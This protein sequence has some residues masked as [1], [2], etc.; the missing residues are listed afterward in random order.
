MFQLEDGVACLESKI[1][2][3]GQ[4]LKQLRGVY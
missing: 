3:Y 4:I 1:V 2:V